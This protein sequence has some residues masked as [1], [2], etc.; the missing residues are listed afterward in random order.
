[1]EKVREAGK[2]RGSIVAPPPPANPAELDA[3][4]LPKLSIDVS[5][6][7]W[8]ARE[9]G[10]ETGGGGLRGGWEER[11]YRVSRKMRGAFASRD[12]SGRFSGYCNREFE[13]CVEKEGGRRRRGK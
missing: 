2:R 8:F 13:G 12:V 3:M 5:F 7:L 6:G 1:M 11:G 4:G 9:R 10:R